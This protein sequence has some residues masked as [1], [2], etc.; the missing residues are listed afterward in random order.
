MVFP[1]IK[2]KGKLRQVPRSCT[3][4]LQRNPIWYCIPQILQVPKSS[5]ACK[6]HK[7]I[8]LA[9][10]TS[11]IR[12]GI[13]SNK[14]ASKSILLLFFSGYVIP[15]FTTILCFLFQFA[16]SFLQVTVPSRKEILLI[17]EQS[18]VRLGVFLRIRVSLLTIFH[19][20][21]SKSAN[22]S[23]IFGFFFSFLEKI[24]CPISNQSCAGK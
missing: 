16:T 1:K 20:N 3:S 14:T 5:T 9:W 4:I 21:S 18:S 10:N 6:K 12:C 7:H 8:S 2:R 24:H 11:G 19:K 17:E 22:Y 15:I 13:R 23:S